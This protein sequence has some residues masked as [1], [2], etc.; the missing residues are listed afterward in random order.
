MHFVCSF[1]WKY[2]RLVKLLLILQMKKKQK[3]SEKQLQTCWADGS[4]N[5]VS[6]SLL[7]L[8][9]RTLKK[10]KKSQ[11]IV[12]QTDVNRWLLLINCWYLAPFIPVHPVYGQF[13]SQH[14]WGGTESY[15]HQSPKYLLSSPLDNKASR[16]L[17]QKK[18]CYS[19][20]LFDFADNI[21]CLLTFKF[22]L[23]MEFSKQI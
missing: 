6:T 9:F 13:L 18:H 5:L 4:E 8:P 11:Q 1:W 17:P 15:S 12:Y 20:N 3:S 16:Y 14:S 19:R 10:K 2:F 7:F 23:L 22:E 21:P